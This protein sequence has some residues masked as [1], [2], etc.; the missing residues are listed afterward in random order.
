MKELGYEQSEPTLIYE[1]NKV[2]YQNDILC[3]QHPYCELSSYWYIQHFATYYEIGRMPR[4]HHYEHISPRSSVFLMISQS[5]LAG[6]YIS[7]ITLAASWTLIIVVWHTLWILPYFV[8]LYALHIFL[9]AYFIS[10]LHFQIWYTYIKATSGLQ[11]S[12]FSCV[13]SIPWYFWSW[14]GIGWRTDHIIHILRDIRSRGFLT[15]S[16]F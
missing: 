6:S 15:S 7:R 1:D 14:E 16:T 9:F 3:A 13:Q 4:R 2:M 12:P 11:F 5:Q 10:C 8:F